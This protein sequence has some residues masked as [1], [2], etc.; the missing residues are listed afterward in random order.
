MKLKFTPSM[1]QNIFN[2][3]KSFFTDS[4]A[5]YSLFDDKRTMPSRYTKSFTILNALMEGQRLTQWEMAKMSGTERY[6]VR[7]LICQFRK[8]G[9]P[10]FNERIPNSRK[11]R[12]FLAKTNEH[13][14]GVNNKVFTS[15]KVP[16]GQHEMKVVR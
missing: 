6:A 1:A 5:Y 10:I 12:Y 2:K 15:M 9:Y 3:I 14:V 4:T 13:D 8:K 11:T 7:A 16:H